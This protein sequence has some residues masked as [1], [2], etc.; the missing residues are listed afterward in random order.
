MS[1]PDPTGEPQDPKLTYTVEQMSRMLDIISDVMNDQRS[2]ILLISQALVLAGHR[3]EA[4]EQVLVKAMGQAAPGT[5]AFPMPPAP[6]P[7]PD[8][9]HGVYL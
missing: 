6:G 8:E 1:F 9:V 2:T 4:L 7:V 5:G 3:I